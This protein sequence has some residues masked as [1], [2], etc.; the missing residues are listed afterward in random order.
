[1][2][3][4]KASAE[5]VL[6][7]ISSSVYQYPGVV[8]QELVCVCV[9]VCV[10]WWVKEALPGRI[11][12]RNLLK[13]KKYPQWAPFWRKIL[14]S[15]IFLSINVFT[16]YVDLFESQCIFTFILLQD[17]VIANEATDKQLISRIYKQLLRLNSRKINDPIKKW[18]KELNRHFSKEDKEDSKEDKDG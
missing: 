11:C 10:Q 15:L 1:M 2:R 13:Q 8:Y 18:A 9:C 5:G 6:L 16:V 17:N 4:S 12:W 3:V 7:S 14:F